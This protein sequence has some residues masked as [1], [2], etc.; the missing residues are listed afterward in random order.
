MGV[1][2]DCDDVVVYVDIFCPLWRVCWSLVGGIKMLHFVYKPDA[3]H[4][5]FFTC[6]YPGVFFF[7]LPSRFKFNGLIRKLPFA[8]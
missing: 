1:G 5:L 3:K 8:D 7:P 6:A 2:C 4:A